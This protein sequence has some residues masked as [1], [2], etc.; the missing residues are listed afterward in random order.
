MFIKT[1]EVS[2]DDSEFYLCAYTIGE[3]KKSIK[4]N[5]RVCGSEV[6]SVDNPA[7]KIVIENIIKTNSNVDAKVYN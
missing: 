4:I 6:I 2:S 5:Y 3:I 7:F 1:V